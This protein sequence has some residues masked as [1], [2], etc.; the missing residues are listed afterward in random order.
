MEHEY[1]VGVFSKI[2]Y[3]LLTG[4]MI[5]F[6]SYLIISKPPHDSSL[7]VFILIPILVCL[8]VLINIFKSK[9]TV[10]E[11]SITRARLFY[12]KTLKFDNIKGVRIES[13]IIII[14]PIDVS[15]SR[16]NISNY[17]DLAKSEEL[18]KWLR[19][20]FTDLDK[21]DLE[22]E[23]EALLNDNSLGYTPE[24]REAKISK[25]R[26]IAVAYNI[27]GLVMCFILIFV[28]NSSVSFW[29]GALYPLLG[30]AIMRFSNGLIKF[31]GASQRSLHMGI[32]LGLTMSVINVFILAIAEYEV[33]SFANA[34]PIVAGVTV[35]L[36]I[37][38][39]STGINKIKG[40]AKGQIAAM[41]VIS[42]LYGFANTI[43]VNCFFDRSTPTNFTTTVADEYISSGKGAHYHLK[44]NP[45]LPGQNIREVD[46]SE[47]S[48]Y[49]TPVGSAVFIYG[50][51]GLLN[52]P[53]FDFELDPTPPVPAGLNNGNS[54]TP[55]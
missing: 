38:L 1:K 14:E 21:V 54:P 3:G 48:Y 49:K 41:V 24:E 2:L 10:T 43:V 33:L 39:Y 29:T 13:K 18:T 51:K 34:W 46:V 5:V 44:L 6:F 12:S 26:Q 37:L 42:F 22:K 15:Y 11:T 25:M 40:V 45:W 28:R 19:E 55:R 20:K 23:K 47:K 32:I 53:W 31:V 8:C 50:K 30:I 52:I 27:W 17:D 35:A 36:F 7:Y 16:I 4:G 9:V